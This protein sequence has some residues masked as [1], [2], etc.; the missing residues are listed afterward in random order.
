MGN[1][2]AVLH[3]PHCG[4]LDLTTSVVF[5]LQ[6]GVYSEGEKRETLALMQVLRLAT[7]SKNVLDAHVQATF[8]HYKNVCAHD[9]YEMRCGKECLELERCRVSQGVRQQ[10]RYGEGVGG[11]E[12]VPIV[13]YVHGHPRLQ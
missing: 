10:A 6:E 5:I 3:P 9:E 11:L 4:A 8:E 2:T 1:S 7:V 12:L 13:P